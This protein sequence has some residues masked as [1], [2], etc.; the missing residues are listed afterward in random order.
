MNYFWLDKHID[1]WNAAIGH[2][3]KP[4]AVIVNGADGMG[5][6]ELLNQI[7]AD[8]VCRQVSV[9]HCGK[10]QNCTLYKQGYHPDVHNVEPEKNVVKVNM[11]RKLTEFFTSTPHCSDYKIAVINQADCMNVAAANALLKVLEEP[12]ARGILFLSTNSKHQLMPTIKSRCVSLDVVLNVGDKIKLNEWLKSELMNQPGQENAEKLSVQDALTLSDFQPIS[13]LKLLQENQMIDFKTQLDYLYE[14][15][16]QDTSVSVAAK[17]IIENQGNNNWALLQRY[18]LQLLKSIFN[19]K[20]HEIYATHPL[21]KLIKKSPK[22]IHIIIK[23][24]EL[25]QQLMLNLNNQIKDQLLLESMLVE[26][27]NQFNQRS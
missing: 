18:F 5:K 16:N 11:I 7:I 2:D 4:Q 17:Q 23:M 24:T 10:C 9:G 13:T 22:V 25:V 27:K 6:A 20:Q 12:P 26:I 14:F 1:Q 15:F 3:H 21:N 8:L 19:Q